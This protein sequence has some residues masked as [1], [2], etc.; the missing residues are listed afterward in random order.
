MNRGPCAVAPFMFAPYGAFRAKV[1]VC[2]A[3]A[4]Q[5]VVAVAV[6]RLCSPLE[7]GEQPR[8]VG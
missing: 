3:A 8:R 1:S 7:A 6:Q 4:V 5:E 2:V